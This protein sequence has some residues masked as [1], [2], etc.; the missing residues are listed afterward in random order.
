[1]ATPL[2]TIYYTDEEMV[3]QSDTELLGSMVESLTVEFDQERY[4]KFLSAGSVSPNA[5]QKFCKVS[6]ET[7]LSPSLSE[8]S[9]DEDRRKSFKK[10]RHPSPM[11]MSK[12]A[13][14]TKVTCGQRFNVMLASKDSNAQ[15]AF[16]ESNIS[17][18]SIWPTDTLFRLGVHQHPVKPRGTPIA[19]LGVRLVVWKQLFEGKPWK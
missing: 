17:L 12:K 10:A 9:S 15:V 3:A 19:I 11:A 16:K 14:T 18:P 7:P 1:M 2:G 6:Q 4:G 8:E 13:S 5:T